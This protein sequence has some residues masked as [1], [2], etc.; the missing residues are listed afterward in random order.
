MFKRL[1]QRWQGRWDGRVEGSAS[2]VL[3]KLTPEQVWAF[4]R[5]AESAVLLDPDVVRAFTVPRTGPGVGEQQCFVTRD[6][7]G[8][9]ATT[10]IEVVAYQD[11]VFAEYRG[12]D[13]PVESASRVEVEA[14]D[15][16][17]CLTMTTWCVVPRIDPGTAR[18]ARGELEE[19]SRRYL[20]RVHAILVAG[21]VP[22]RDGQ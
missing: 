21:F 20:A 10:Y 12:T 5:P 8:R 19:Q 13:Q 17:T 18:K 1:E 9:E 15:G 7:S 3:P 11:G 16:G 4:V 2:I 6:S 22:S 14:V